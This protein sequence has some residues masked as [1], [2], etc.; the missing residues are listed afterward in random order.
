MIGPGRS[1]YQCHI[2][3]KHCR[4][5]DCSSLQI[6]Q[7]VHVNSQIVNVLATGPRYVLTARENRNI[8]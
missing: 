4:L 7:L 6:G 3:Q 8:L 5:C 2:S 1:R